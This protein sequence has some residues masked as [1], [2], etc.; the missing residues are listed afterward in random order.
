MFA[1][2]DSPKASAACVAIQSFDEQW[3]KRKVNLRSQHLK[4]YQFL[5]YFKNL[6]WK[7][8]LHQL[9][10]SKVL[11]IP[12]IF[13]GLFQT[14]NYFTVLAD[15]STD[16]SRMEQISI[17]I[18]YWDATDI[19]EEFLGFVDRV[20]KRTNALAEI[21]MANISEIRHAKA[22][23]LGQNYN[24]VAKL[25]A[26]WGV[27]P[28]I[29]KEQHSAANYVHCSAHCRNLTLVKTAKVLPISRACAQISH[30]SLRGSAKRSVAFCENIGILQSKTRK[31]AK[32]R[33]FD[34]RWVERHNAVLFSIQLKSSIE[35]AREYIKYLAGENYAFDCCRY[36]AWC[37]HCS[38]L[39]GWLWSTYFEKLNL[40][41]L[42][43]TDLR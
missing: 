31:S 32:P 2:L 14:S 8:V 4:W 40:P 34:T 12:S 25:S 37:F 1:Q 19:R 10:V 7:S 36:L 22:H 43:F 6:Q 29:I 23:L 18:R 16:I 30:I 39:P 9:S 17:Y 33:M 27:L 35:E 3:P 26:N 5:K 13:F 20:E 21:I 38:W 28:A 24:R 42:L 15:R 11:I 41:A